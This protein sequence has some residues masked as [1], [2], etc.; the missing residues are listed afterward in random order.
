MADDCVTK[1]A[2]LLVKVCVSQ[3]E[4]VEY[5]PEDPDRIINQQF[6]SIG[7]LAIR[8]TAAA[9]KSLALAHSC[10]GCQDHRDSIESITKDEICALILQ[11]L[12]AEKA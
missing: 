6:Q 12:E 1:V 9:T 11:A 10:P 2:E 8:T 4:S 3:T 5:D 7:E